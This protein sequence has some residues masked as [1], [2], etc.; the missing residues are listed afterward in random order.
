MLPRFKAAEYFCMSDVSSASMVLA[1][2]PMSA[3]PAVIGYALNLL[4]VEMRTFCEKK[5]Q[6]VIDE[7]E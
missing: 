2:D 4:S 7:K 6:E 5:A 3:R 1:D